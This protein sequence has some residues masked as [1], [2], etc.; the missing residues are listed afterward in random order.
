MNLRIW[1]SKMSLSQ[2]ETKSPRMETTIEG[3]KVDELPGIR[4]EW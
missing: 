1:S 2:T 3:V 4:K